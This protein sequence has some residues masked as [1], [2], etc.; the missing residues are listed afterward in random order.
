MIIVFIPYSIANV[1]AELTDPNFS[2][3]AVIMKFFEEGVIAMINIFPLW[4]L[5]TDIFFVGLGLLLMYIWSRAWN[6]QCRIQ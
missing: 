3:W 6:A 2:M 4:F 1:I 5:I